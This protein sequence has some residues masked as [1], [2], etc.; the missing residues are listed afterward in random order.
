MHWWTS[1]YE[2]GALHVLSMCNVLVSL[3]LW[4]NRPLHFGAHLGALIDCMCLFWVWSFVMK[5]TLTSV[6]IFASLINLPQ[7]SVKSDMWYMVRGQQKAFSA[8]GLKLPRP[9]LSPPQP[10]HSLLSILQ[11][12]F[13]KSWPTG[14]QPWSLNKSSN[15]FRMQLYPLKA[16]DGYMTMCGK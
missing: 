15:Y 7:P 11:M 8:F 6:L 2:S 14:E 13:F 1:C 16:L 5:K 10:A 4:C 12:T 3:V 9:P